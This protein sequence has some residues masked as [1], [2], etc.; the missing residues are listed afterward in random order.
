MVAR[1]GETLSGTAVGLS[2]EGGLVIET[3]TGK[4]TVYAGDVSILI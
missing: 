1:S 3:A 4:S 2:P